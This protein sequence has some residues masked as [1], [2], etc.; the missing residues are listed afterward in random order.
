MLSL[1]LQANWRAGGVMSLERSYVCS[2]LFCCLHRYIF[3]VYLLFLFVLSLF[4]SKL[5]T[6]WDYIFWFIRGLISVVLGVF[7]PYDPSTLVF[8]FSLAFGLNMFNAQLKIGR[9]TC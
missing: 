5:I 8:V 9:I 3:T 7:L 6:C 4:F 1:A 2:G